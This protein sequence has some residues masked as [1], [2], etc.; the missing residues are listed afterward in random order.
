MTAGYSGTPLERKLGVKAESR[1]ALVDPPAGFEFDA[2]L[3]PLGP[4]LDVIVFFVTERH[5][6]EARLDGLIALLRPAGALWIARPKATSG[7]ATD[8]TEHVP[9]EVIL[10][11]G[12]VDN[13]ICA[14]SEV[15]SGTRFV[16]R[17]RNR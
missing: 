12:L 10:P 15:W 5:E 2:R 3:V 6:L 8:V 7:V 17:L 13:K 16:W 4:D 11:R 14:I 1:V 9:R